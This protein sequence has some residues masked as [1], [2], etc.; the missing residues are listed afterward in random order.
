MNQ[1][2]TRQGH[3]CIGGFGGTA[4]GTGYRAIIKEIAGVAD[5]LLG[6]SDVLGILSETD[7]LTAMGN[8]LA[9][10][11]ENA[12][13]ARD[14]LLEICEALEELFEDGGDDEC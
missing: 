6:M 3:I 14:N 12:L 9:L 2:T 13:G 4:E 7:P 10:M 1:D 11:K 5:V 8:A